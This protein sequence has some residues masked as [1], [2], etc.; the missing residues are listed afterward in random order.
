MNRTKNAVEFRQEHYDGDQ[1]C[2]Y[3]ACS[4]PKATRRLV[5]THKGGVLVGLSCSKGRH[6][7]LVKGQLLKRAGLES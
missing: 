1:K 2:E 3:Q 4:A 6:T 7:I 5:L